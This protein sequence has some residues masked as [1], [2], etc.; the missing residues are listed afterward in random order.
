LCVALVAV[1]WL[2]VGCATMRPLKPGAA[3]VSTP[4]GLVATVAQSENPVAATHQT[5]V[6]RTTTRT[7]PRPSAEGCVSVVESERTITTDIGPAQKDTARELA[8]RLASMRAVMWVGI[9]LLVGGPLVGWRLGWFTNGLVAGGV[10]LGL[11]VLAQVLPGNEA[12]LGLLGLGVV[13]VV[14][15]VYYRAQHDATATT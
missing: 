5:I 4:Q 7:A 6:E 2:L 14:A 3:S 15:Y 11:I 8:A 9:V 13:P 1:C 12:W 10:G